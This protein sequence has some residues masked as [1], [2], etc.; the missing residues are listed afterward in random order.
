MSLGAS[1]IRGLLGDL[2]DEL[3]QRGVTADVFLVGGAAMALAYNSRR[4]TRDVDGVFEPKQVVYDAAAV[5][6]ERRG[7]GA[8]WLNDAVK[9][10][11]HGPDPQARPVF[12]GAGLRVD[13]ASPEYLLAMKLR[14]A[15]PED[16][17]DIRVLYA[18]CGYDR[19][20]PGL[21]LAQD[22]YPGQVP[23]RAQFMVEEMFGPEESPAEAQTPTAQP[24]AEARGG[25]QA[26][27]SVC[28]RP[29]RAAESVARGACPRC[30]R[31]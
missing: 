22:A 9:A 10:Y 25:A 12:E 29:L 27:C 2:S 28:G 31:R 20:E 18:A 13:V 16:V 14:A 26:R 23:A 21:E 5:V 30:A 24:P 4:A 1:D 3:A 6:G 7:V 17:E 11:L 19:A 8:Y 15:R